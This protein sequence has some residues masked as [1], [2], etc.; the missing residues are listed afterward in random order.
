[1]WGA[2]VCQPP[3]LADKLAVAPDVPF[4]S[5][6]GDPAEAWSR[7]IGRPVLLF[8]RIER[9]RQVAFAAL[10][11]SGPVLLAAN[12]PAEVVETVKRLGGIPHFVELDSGLGWNES[13]LEA[14]SVA[15]LTEQV[16]TGI[17]LPISEHPPSL[18]DCAASLPLPDCDLQS[19]IG[20]FGLFLPG[21]ALLAFSDERL[22]QAA[23]RL[24]NS[25]DAPDPARA[26]AQCQRL[27]APG[28]LVERQQSVLAELRRGLE[29]AAGLPLWPENR[30]SLAHGIGVHIPAETDAATFWAYAKAENTPLDWLPI[31]QPV[32]YRALPGC[33]RSAE[34]LLRWLLVPAN[35]DYGERELRAAVLG[36]VKAAEYLGVRWR[37]NPQQARAYAAMMDEMY[38]P[39]HNAYRPLFEVHE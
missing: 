10:Q 14:G 7:A 21:G 24:T 22:Y 36:V 8:E 37:T 29:Q 19:D 12:A 28:G 3:R 1:M 33:R 15:W 16:G 26:L 20:V 23:C 31:L 30:L 38:G 39:E 17:R 2:D 18:A 11:V 5:L 4:P 13:V 34:Q 6:T 9:A 27:Y 25:G 32:H 35:P